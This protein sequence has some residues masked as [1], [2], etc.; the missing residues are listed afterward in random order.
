M[1]VIFRQ[2][3]MREPHVCSLQSTL[4]INLSY[5][6]EIKCIAVNPVKPH[7]IAVG[8]DDCFV[9][10]YD[11]RM[12]RTIPYKTYVSIIKTFYCTNYLLLLISVT[13]EYCAFA[14]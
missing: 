6:Y 7:Y 2:Y 1:F 14:Y 8:C 11:R 13:T 10:L 5:A 3:D 12:V 9:R 4:L